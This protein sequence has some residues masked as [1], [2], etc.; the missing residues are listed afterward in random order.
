MKHHYVPEFLQRPWADTNPDGKLEVFR[1]DIEGLPS[2][3]HAPKHTGYEPD[4]YALSMPVVA[5][6]KKHAVEEQ[7][8]KYVDNSGALVRDKLENQGLKK[9]SPKDRVDWTRFLMSLRIR[10]PGIVQMLITESKE[11]LRTTLETQPE[12]YEEFAS[13]GHPPT[14]VEWTEKRFPGLIENFGLSFFHELVDNPDI[15]DKIL[16]MKWWIWDFSSAPYDLL[17]AD[18]PCIFTTGIDDPNLVIALPITPKKAFMATQSEHVANTM[19]LQHPRGLATRLNEASL[20]Q[21][22]VRI[23]ARD[24]APEQFLRNR[25]QRR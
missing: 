13:L 18:H 25:L 12:Q 4:L 21:A 20:N 11:H 16:R 6:M 19:R 17:L 15:G 2:R 8:L 9:L 14:L 10:Q 7:F 5:G 3:R 23:Y 24:R 22:R 1:L